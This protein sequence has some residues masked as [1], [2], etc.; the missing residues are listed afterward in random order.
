MS[1]DQ[2]GRPPPHNEG[3]VEHKPSRPYENKTDEVQ[4]KTRERVGDSVKPK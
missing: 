1:N 2:R 4:R 3:R